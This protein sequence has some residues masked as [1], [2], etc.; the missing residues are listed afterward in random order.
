MISGSAIR[1]APST[2]KL[3]IVF[4]RSL[5]WC[6]L[7]LSWAS[8]MFW[9]DYGRRG[10]WRTRQWFPCWMD[11]PPMLVEVLSLQ[12]FTGVE[13][14]FQLVSARYSHRLGN[15]PAHSV[16]VV[17]DQSRKTVA[18][19][20]TTAACLVHKPQIVLAVRLE[21][22]YVNPTDRQIRRLVCSILRAAFCP[23]HRQ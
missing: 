2:L 4:S 17:S 7:M 23:C 22:I 21:P 15:I 20:L 16:M 8:R 11:K 13:K 12:F 3:A 6:G 1:A 10:L 19:L 9:R 14:S 5:C 18:T